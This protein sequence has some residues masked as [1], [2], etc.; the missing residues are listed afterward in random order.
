MLAT[1]LRALMSTLVLG[2]TVAVAP[3]AV[4]AAAPAAPVPDMGSQA[5]IADP[6]TVL[7]P[8]WRRSSDL[9]VAGAGDTNGFHVYLAREKDAFAWST[10]ATLNDGQNGVGSWTGYV[11]LTGSGRYAVVVYAPV[12]ATNKPARMLAGAYAAVVDVRTGKARQVVRGVQLAYFN[13]ACGPGDRV[14]LTRAIGRDHEETDL[15]TVDAA[16]ARVTETRRI[17]AQ[18]TTPAPAADG[19]YGVVRGELVRVGKGGRLTRLATPG[20]QPYAVR[21]TADGAVDLLTVKPGGEAEQ[22]AAYR[23]RVGRLTHLGTSPGKQLELL[24]LSGGRN[25]LIGEIDGLTKG[26]AKDLVLLRSSRPARAVSREGHLM[27]HGMRTERQDARTSKRAPGDGE[28]RVTVQAPRAGAVRSGL[29]RTERRTAADVTVLAGPVPAGMAALAVPPDPG[30]PRCAIPRNNV[31]YQVF[32]PSAN[33]VEW[34]VDLAVN[35]LLRVDRT[36]PGIP[37]YKPQVMFSLPAGSPL[38]PAQLM[39]AILAQETNL[40]QASWHAVPGDAGNPLISDYYGNR[41]HGENIKIIDYGEA[42]CGYGISQVTD[43]MASGQT[44]YSSEQQE[45]IAVD[46]MANIAAGLKILVQKWQEVQATGSQVNNGDPRYIENWFLAVWG[47]NSG[48]Y[49]NT[50]GP[51]GVGWFNNPANPDYPANRTPFLRASL[52][53]A[54][55]PADW[56]YP[57]KIMGW[58]ETPQWQWIPPLTKYAEPNFG[59]GSGDVLQLPGRFQFCGSVN[60]CTP[61]ASDPCPSWNSNCWWHG[62]TSWGDGCAAKCATGNLAHSLSAPEPPVSYVYSPSCTPFQADI[63]TVAAVIDN[64]NNESGVN[65]L[66]CAP[67]PRGGKFTLRTGS[68][69]GSTAGLYGQVDLHQLGAGYLGH[70]WFTHS[71]DGA[72]AQHHRVLGTWTTDLPSDDYEIVVHLPSHGANEQVKYVISQ[73]DGGAGGSDH[74][75]VCEIDQNVTAYDDKWVSL[76]WTWLYPGA[77]VQLDNIVDGADGTVDVAY[78]AIA[79]VNVPGYANGRSCGSPYP[80]S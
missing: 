16:A 18:F 11:C 31:Y 74:Q 70:T 24:G 25:A 60:Y 40:A 3:Q 21:A 80:M 1:R 6:A 73:G 41:P 54:S 43:G 34:A 35:N 77:K 58:A 76:G 39:L 30:Q 44:S 20:G 56:S 69:F 66:G 26:S 5:S 36:I 55:H 13:P 23:Y 67:Q 12:I 15:L 50:G 14:L 33:Q 49:Q 59:V 4:S 2:A 72:D 51:Y 52:D 42:D 28:L 62:T 64:L 9:L 71:Y 61:N 75:I 32:Q 78:D 17:K 48:I 63:G 47:Y 79:F 19:D 46:Y 10:L 68:P 27:V 53:D 45:A 57:E 65:R 8:G 7:G 29:V 37:T 22:S 38:V